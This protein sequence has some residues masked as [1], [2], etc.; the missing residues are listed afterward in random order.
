MLRF[1][2]GTNLFE[3]A[4]RS[5]KRQ[6]GSMRGRLVVVAGILLG[7]GLG[8]QAQDQG[9][10]ATATNGGKAAGPEATSGFGN[11]AN[12]ARLDEM[13]H[14][15]VF[16]MGKVAV[17]DA[18]MP[19]D[20]IPVVVICNKSDEV[21]YR[22]EADAK[23]NF[24]IR[25]AYT[26]PLHS[27]VTP[28]IKNPH[29]EAAAQL[30]GCNIH[31]VLPGFKSSSLH[32]AY[33]SIMDDP[34]LGTV[35]LTPDSAAVGSSMSATYAKASPEAMKQYDKAR[36]EFVS[37]NERG[38]E[39]D[40]EKTVKIDPQFADAWYHLGKLQQAKKPADALS[41]YQKAVAAD[42]NFV[43]PYLPIAE[44]AA[45]QKNWKEVKSATDLAL[46]LD[47]QGNPQILYYSAVGNYNVGNVNVAEANAQKSLAMDPQ[48]T[49]PNTEQLLAVML[50]S[51]GQL[52]DALHHLQHSLTY[53]KPGPNRDLVQQQIAQLEKAMPAG[54]N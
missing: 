9:G 51:Q 5:G 53:L 7:L 25:P 43:S 16:F 47:P 13:Q 15:S 18:P 31:A 48:H 54:S 30:T 24:T 26:G 49:A 39:K 29:Q 3:R 37:G 28:T 12:Y 8:A 17:E 38:A 19:W 41:S 14:G 6:E 21:R 22:T 35:T 32:I 11:E 40:L 27:E 1:D 50:A 34:N 46:K 20:P 33:T 23:G 4:D 52:A 2:D 44:L 36:K 42:P 45:D 10:V